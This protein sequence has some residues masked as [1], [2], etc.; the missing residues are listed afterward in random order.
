LLIVAGVPP[1]LERPVPLL[2][3]YRGI[4]RETLARRLNEA[5]ARHE[6]TR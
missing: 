4:A 6:T 2:A 1:V 3:K 5:D